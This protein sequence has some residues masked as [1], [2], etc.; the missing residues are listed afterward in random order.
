[1][2]FYTYPSSGVQIVYPMLFS[3]HTTL[4]QHLWHDYNHSRE[5]LLNMPWPAT[6]STTYDHPPLTYNPQVNKTIPPTNKTKHAWML[7]PAGHHLPFAIHRGQKHLLSPSTKIRTSPHP[8]PSHTCAALV[9]CGGMARNAFSLLPGPFSW[10]SLSNTV[11]C[12]FDIP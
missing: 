1:M 7:T 2:S 5:I 8:F 10:H 11:K 9:K 12:L 6:I 3:K 4:L